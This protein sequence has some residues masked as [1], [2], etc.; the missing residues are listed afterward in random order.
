MTEGIE[1]ETALNTDLMRENTIGY[2][3]TKDGS[4]TPVVIYSLGFDAEQ[5]LTVYNALRTYL[6]ANVQQDNEDLETIK[7][8]AA[9]LIEIKPRALKASK[10]LALKAVGR[11]AR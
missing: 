10:Y 9:M 3:A 5:L 11:E 4:L 8:I 2:N 7:Q 6:R 1:Q